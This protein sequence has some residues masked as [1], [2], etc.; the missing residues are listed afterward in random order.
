MPKNVTV[1][2]RIPAKIPISSRAS[3]QALRVDVNIAGS[4]K[5]TLNIGRRTVEWWPEYRWVN[6]HRL[7]WQRFIELLE[8]MPQRRS[9]RRIAKKSN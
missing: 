5:G 1:I 7:S 8:Q 4:K 6:A 3:S 2:A 9:R